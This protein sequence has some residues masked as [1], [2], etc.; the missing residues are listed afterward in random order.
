MKE[1]AKDNRSHKEPS[2]DECCSIAES[3]MDE[4][5]QIMIP[6][7]ALMPYVNNG[8]GRQ[9]GSL[10]RRLLKQ[11]RQAKVLSIVG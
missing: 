5:H 10:K 4:I 2:L 3:M 9:K 1:I 11:I 7:N 8:D 6:D